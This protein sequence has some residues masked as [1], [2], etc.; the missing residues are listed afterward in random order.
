MV[1]LA[2]PEEAEDAEAGPQGDFRSAEQLRE[3]PGHLRVAL[4]PAHALRPVRCPR[5]RAQLVRYHSGVV[6]DDSAGRQR[7]QREVDILDDGVGAHAQLLQDTGAP[8]PIAPCE[9]GEVPQRGAAGLP[10]RAE[11]VLVAAAEGGEG[12]GRGVVDDAAALDAVDARG[13][14][15]RC[16]E[17]G[18]EWVGKVVGVEEGDDAVGVEDAE[19]MVDVF[20][21]GEGVGDGVDVEV[22][23]KLAEVFQMGFDKEGMRSVVDQVN[24][25]LCRGIVKFCESVLEGVEDDVL[26]IGK[27]GDEDDIEKW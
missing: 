20:G 9:E 15:A 26:F 8:I 23:V 14:E 21:F 1:E 11:A 17:A 13:G 10:E 18:G 12:G 6:H 22:F 25:D 19:E 4:R 2:D 27:I 5:R 24:T 16:G 3:L 7:A